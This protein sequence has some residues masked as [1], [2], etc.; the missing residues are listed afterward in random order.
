MHAIEDNQSLAENAR[1][2]VLE[3]TDRH[4]GDLHAKNRINEYLQKA[5]QTLEQHTSHHNTVAKLKCL[6]VSVDDISSHGAL[7]VKTAHIAHTGEEILKDEWNTFSHYLSRSPHVKQELH[8][9]VDRLNTAID[10]TPSPN[11]EEKQ[12]QLS[13]QESIDHQHIARRSVKY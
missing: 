3:Q 9:N 2:C 12:H 13:E 7:K 5:D 10:R 1:L 6:N 11:K 4:A 8:D